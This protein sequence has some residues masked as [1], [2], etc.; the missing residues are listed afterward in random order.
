MANCSEIGPNAAPTPTFVRRARLQRLGSS[1]PQNETVSSDVPLMSESIPFNKN[2]HSPPDPNYGT[3]PRSL[4]HRRS[5]HFSRQHTPPRLSNVPVPPRSA[6]ASGPS[7]PISMFS[8][9]LRNLSNLS[10]SRIVSQRPISAYDA[11]F[12]SDSKDDGGLGMSMDAKKNGVRVWYS[13]YSS[14]D[15]MHDAIKESLRFSRLRRKKN[16]RA[17]IRLAVDRY[18]LKY[19]CQ[20]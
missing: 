6:A 10:F 5:L 7:S 1:G 2:V 12:N 4:F 14:I 9:S 20:K 19:S 16:F 18:V 15:W 3:L 8:P 17:R 11:T 13:S